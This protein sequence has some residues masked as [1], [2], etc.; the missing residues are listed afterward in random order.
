MIVLWLGRSY[1]QRDQWDEFVEQARDVSPDPPPDDAPSHP[2]QAEFWAAIAEL[3]N[4][5]AA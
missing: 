1:V 2:L 3:D 4:K 5:P